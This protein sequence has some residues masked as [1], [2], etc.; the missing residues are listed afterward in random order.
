TQGQSHVKVWVG[1]SSA[2][3]I[4]NTVAL[5]AFDGNGTLIGQ[6]TAHLGPSNAAIPVHTPLQFN[7]AAAKIRSVKITFLAP[8]NGSAFNNGLVV[9][10]FEFNSPGG[11]PHCTALVRPR[12]EIAQ[13]AANAI[14]QSNSFPLQGNIFTPTALESATL[15]VTNSAGTK[16]S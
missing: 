7:S 10:D 1:F 11:P 8:P 14:F 12:I 15:A 13:P 3:T 2:T 16:S 4:A 6:A 9:D 5:Q